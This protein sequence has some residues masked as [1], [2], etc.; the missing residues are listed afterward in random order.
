MIINFYIYANAYYVYNLWIKVSPYPMVGYQPALEDCHR[1][2]KLSPRGGAM[3]D[4]D[5][6]VG[7]W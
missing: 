6:P 3:I 5:Q 1:W 7:P 2:E 4:R